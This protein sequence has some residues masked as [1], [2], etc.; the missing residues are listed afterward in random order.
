MA[1]RPRYAKD[2]V[3]G[4]SI[5]LIASSQCQC[6]VLS[7]ILSRLPLPMVLTAPWLYYTNLT[8]SLHYALNKNTF[9]Q[10]IPKAPT[11]LSVKVYP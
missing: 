2:L 5:R 9:S 7:A 1:K 4:V 6:S 11:Q 10:T 8:W 3:M